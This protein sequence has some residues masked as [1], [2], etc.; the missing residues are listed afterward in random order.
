[1]ASLDDVDK[2]NAIKQGRQKRK[3]RS[4]LWRH[5]GGDVL[6]GILATGAYSYAGRG[7]GGATENLACK[8]FCEENSLHP[9]IMQRIQKMRIQLAKLAKQ[10]LGNAK[11][12]AAS[13]GKILSSMPPPKNTEENLLRQVRLHNY[14]NFVSR[15]FSYTRFCSFFLEG[16][17]FWTS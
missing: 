14:R 3:E 10:R 6:A 4:N 7:A 13:S 17:H 15:Y 9:V 5:D 16:D 12:V 8:R 2:A 1:M 11:G